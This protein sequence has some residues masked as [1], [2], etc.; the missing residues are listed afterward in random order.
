MSNWVQ[1]MNDGDEPFAIRLA[2]HLGW[3]L[4]VGTPSDPLA[5]NSWAHID[6]VPDD[7]GI[8]HGKVI[9]I[10]GQ[11]ANPVFDELTRDEYEPSYMVYVRRAVFRKITPDDKGVFIQ[12]GIYRR[13]SVAV[14]VWG[15]AGANIEDTG[16]S[17]RYIIENGLPGG[18]IGPNPELFPP[19]IDPPPPPPTNQSWI[20][21]FEMPVNPTPSQVVE[22]ENFLRPLTEIAGWT[23]LGIWSEGNILNVAL[24]K[25]GSPAILL[26]II[27]AIMF[28]FGLAPIL[29]SFFNWNTNVEETK[30][31]DEVGD[32]IGEANK[33]LS[34]GTITP[35]QYQQILDIV[36]Q[37]GITPPPGDGIGGLFGSLQGIIP[38]ILILAVISA[39]P[40]GKR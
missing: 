10:G 32:I 40:K 28:I 11:D 29:V 35:E 34:D 1:A 13:G 38:L 19:P 22:L 23:G 17:V 31:M 27:A 20:Y 37:E 7:E 30:Q 5:G 6:E 16:D 21:R 26:L 39:I 4:A 36:K 2:N 18:T 33:M 3:N 14:E 25:V 8:P 9:V 24:V 12:K 15:V